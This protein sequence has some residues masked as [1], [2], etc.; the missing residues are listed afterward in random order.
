MNEAIYVSIY[1]DSPAALTLFSERHFRS[2]VRTV[3]LDTVSQYSCAIAR[4]PIPLSWAKTAGLP[5]HLDV[6]GCTGAREVVVP[7]RGYSKL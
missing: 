2:A 5:L 1:Q 3:T 7:I 4:S 6:A